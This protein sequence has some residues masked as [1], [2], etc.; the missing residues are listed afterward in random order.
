MKNCIIALYAAVI[1]FLSSCSQSPTEVTRKFTENISNGKIEEAKKYA[2][3]GT[4]KML[5]LAGS[6]GVMKVD[7]DFRF[8]KVR[9]SIANNRAW[10]TFV[11]GKN[12]TTVELAKIDGKWI[13]V[14]IQ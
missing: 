2:S 4:A 13:V 5:D 6:M 8:Q 1:T 14:H 3:E 7:P 11:D 12:H 9:D 10:V